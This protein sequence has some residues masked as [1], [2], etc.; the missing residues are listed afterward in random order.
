MTL[1]LNDDKWRKRSEE[2]C[3]WIIGSNNTNDT[4]DRV[5]ALQLA[6]VHRRLGFVHAVQHRIRLAS[7]EPT[8]PQNLVDR[9]TR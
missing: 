3:N 6:G 9:E 5:E 1:D 4:L 7:S 2:E 8:A